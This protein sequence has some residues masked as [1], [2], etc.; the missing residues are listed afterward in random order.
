MSAETSTLFDFSAGSTVTLTAGTDNKCCF[1]L[2]DGAAG[3]YWMGIC[4]RGTTDLVGANTYYAAWPSRAEGFTWAAADTPGPGA[5]TVILVNKDN[6]SL[7]YEPIATLE[8]TV[9]A[10]EETSGVDSG[11]DDSDGGQQQV[12]EISGEFLF[13]HPEGDERRALHE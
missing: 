11:A 12:V 1:V 5:Y 10:A 9:E 8:L 4:P 2:P 7:P 13:F 3:T 6:K